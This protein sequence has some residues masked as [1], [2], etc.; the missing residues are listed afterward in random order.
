MEGILYLIGAFLVGDLF[1]R[2]VLTFV[3][4]PHRLAAG[5]LAGLSLVT[6]PTYL[7]ALAFCRTETPLL[8]ANL[9]VVAAA[10]PL[11]AWKGWPPGV[12][13]RSLTWGDLLF[14]GAALA[15]SCYLMFSTFWQGGGKLNM[16]SVVWNDFG[17]NLSLVQSFAVGHN[18]P[19]EYPHFSG[20]PIRYHFFYWFLTGNLTF[21]GLPIDWSLNLLSSLTLTAML[22]LVAVFGQVVFSSKAVGRLGAALFFFHGTLFYVPFLASAGSPSAAL[23]SVLGLK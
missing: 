19:T 21:L 20:S 1:C 23:Q 4:L 15:V 22:V 9:L 10:V 7:L 13:W 18:F 6:W 12:P 3:S 17:P 14:V 16:G 8:W 2:R 11:V 5:F